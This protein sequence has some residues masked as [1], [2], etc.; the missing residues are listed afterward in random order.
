[1]KSNE[2]V[3]YITQTVVKYIDQPK[4][5]RKKHRMEKKDMKE[6]FLFRWFGVLPYI[7]YLALNKKKH[8]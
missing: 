7:F 4:D 2:Y 1:M 3:K 8:K 6:P 5:E